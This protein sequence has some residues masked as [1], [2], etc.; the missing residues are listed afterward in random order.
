MSKLPDT[1]HSYL[2]SP[3]TLWFKNRSV[4]IKFRHAFRMGQKILENFRHVAFRSATHVKSHTTV[5]KFIF[6]T[7]DLQAQRITSYYMSNFYPMN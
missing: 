1:A 3:R 7:R 2:D 4:R 5:A 6:S